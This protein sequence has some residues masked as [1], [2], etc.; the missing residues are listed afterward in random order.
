MEEVLSLRGLSPQKPGNA[1]RKKDFRFPTKEQTGFQIEKAEQSCG[2]GAERS[3]DALAETPWP[4]SVRNYKENIAPY[5]LIRATGADDEPE[6]YMLNMRCPPQ[7]CLIVFSCSERVGFH[8]VGGGG[9]D[10]Y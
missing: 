6:R 8:F 3:R 2:P 5:F 1:S 4:R 10:F 9:K 7:S